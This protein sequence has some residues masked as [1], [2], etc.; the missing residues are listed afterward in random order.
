MGLH[1]E[2]Y[3]QPLVLGRLLES[4]LDTVQRIAAAIKKAD[5]DYIFLTARGTSDHAGLY[6]KYLWGMV[7][8]L[9]VA[10]AAPSHFSV[11]KQPPRL[12]RAAV[13]GISQSGQSPDIV[14]V[15]AEGRRQGALTVAIT[16][17][18]DSPL[19]E[20][21]DHVLDISAGP[22]KAV[23]ATKT[24]TAQLMAIGMLSA[25]LCENNQMF[26]RL[27]QVPAQV[28]EMLALDASIRQIT[29]RYR[30][31]THCVVLGRGYNYATAFEWSL[32]LKELTYVVANPYSP[33][34]FQHGP[35][36]IVEEG[37]P[38]L[39]V[40]P[41]G[42]VRENLQALL[43]RLKDELRA[44]LLILSNDEATLDLAH[45]PLKLPKE[46]PEWV[47]PLVSIIPAQLYCYHLTLAKGWDAE[48]P[49][50]LKKV[51]E[52]K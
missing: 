16:N 1:E 7:N 17:A 3:E 28:Q 37:F 35:I 10:L 43:Q 50:G 2:I 12:N 45:T 52:T 15:L 33:A 19:A 25:A 31:M 48:A 8:Q 20:N 46:M 14:S 30:Y 39:A 24:Y 40:A 27:Q 42:A 4:Q 21:A 6:A 38:V 11:Y 13:V 47:S 44:E 41:Q 32:K 9:P 23:A 18:P 34:D 22:E 29:E 49:R 26:E 51:T 36:A 5:I